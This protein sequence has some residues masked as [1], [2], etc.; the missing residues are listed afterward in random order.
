MGAEFAEKY[1][2]IACRLQLEP[3]KCEDPHVERLLEAFAF[4]AARVRLKIDDEFPEI[5]ESLLG[6]LYPHLLA[7]SRRCRSSSSSWTRAGQPPV[8][9]DDPAGLDARLPLRRRHLVPVPDGLPGHDLAA[10]GEPARFELPIPG[11]GPDGRRA[12]DAPSRA[13]GVRRRPPPRAQGEDLRAE[14]KPLESL[15]FYL[16]GEGKVV[17]ALHELLYNDLVAVELRPGGPRDV[18]S[19]VKLPG[20]SSPE[21]A[22]P[23]R[24]APPVR[25]PLFSGYRL[26]PEYFSFPEKFLFFDVDG[27]RAGGPGRLRRRPRDPPL[28]RPRLPA[29]AERLRPDLPAALH[30]RR[31]PLPADRRADPADPPAA[32]VPRHPGR[33]AA[34]TSP[35]STPSSASRASRRGATRS[36]PTSRSSRSATTSRRAQAPAFWYMSRRPRSGRTT[37]GPRSTSPSSTSGSNPVQPDADT[38][39]VD[40]LCTN[41]DLPSRLPFGGAEA[42]FQLEGPGVFSAIR[43]L[44][45]PTPTVTAPLR[46]GACS[47]G[48]S[49]TSSLNLLSLVEREGGQGPG[50]APGDPPPLRLRR[51]V[52]HP[53]ADR[54]DHEGRLAASRP[55]RSGSS[56]P[57][58]VRGI[59]VSVEL[60]E[61]NS[62]SGPGSSSSPRSSSASSASTRP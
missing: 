32:R 6:V 21:S 39:T 2:K 4:L 14:E 42:D 49:R 48:S 33:A 56:S 37:T 50:G 53:A 60:D 9:P 36:R 20:P 12:D 23:R 34:R 17:H 57:S 27:A 47:G 18:P 55:A 40:V 59:E 15:R 19:P 31:Q 8:G 41:R 16:Q 5:T 29:R 62:S 30:A 35:R 43:C 45:T 24:D 44:E 10:R 22:S 58:F 54:R 51:L 13:E 26:L 7:P 46:R 52:R 61:Q 25:R 11:V 1:P 28:L 38:L 3:D